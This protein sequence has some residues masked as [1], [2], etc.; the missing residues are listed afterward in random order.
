MGL[1]HSVRMS[2]ELLNMFIL[3]VNAI[4]FSIFLNFL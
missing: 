1:V 3:V 2:G 4:L